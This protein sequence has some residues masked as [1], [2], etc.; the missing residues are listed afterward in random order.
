[1]HSNPSEIRLHTEYPLKKYE[2]ILILF[3][4]STL[5]NKIYQL[6]KKTQNRISMQPAVRHTWTEKKRYTE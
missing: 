5:F 6:K 3:C 4:K 1:M 2:Q